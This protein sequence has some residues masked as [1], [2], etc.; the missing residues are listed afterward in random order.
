[1][2]LRFKILDVRFNLSDL[3]FTDKDGMDCEKVQWF[4]RKY[5]LKHQ[6]RN[7]GITR[8]I[9][10]KNNPIG[11]FT[12]STSYIDKESID[13]SMR[14][15]TRTTSI[16]PAMIIEYI[17]IDKQKRDG[18]IGSEVLKWIIGFGRNNLSRKIGCRYVILFAKQAISFYK[19][20]GFN[21]AEF[22]NNKSSFYL[23]YRDLFPEC[24]ELEQSN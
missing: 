17:A 11:Y 5:A 24:V 18:G 12:I 20:N 6:Q 13:K 19:K 2:R 9:L 15:F 21:I 3:D 7:L 14:P 1:M 22:K 8:V 4:I 16:F 23:M 10:F